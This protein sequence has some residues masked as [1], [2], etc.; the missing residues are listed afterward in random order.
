VEDEDDDPTSGSQVPSHEGTPEHDTTTA[1]EEL[2][3]SREENLGRL[4][5]VSK[6]RALKTANHDDLYHE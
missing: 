5:E 2:N 1:F 6:L 4:A 3:Q